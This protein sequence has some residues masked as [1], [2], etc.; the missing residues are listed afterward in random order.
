MLTSLTRR[1]VQR[2][3]LC[4]RLGQ[5]L[6]PAAATASAFDQP[7]TLRP[8][9]VRDFVLP[10]PATTEALDLRRRSFSTALNIH[11]NSEH[12]NDET[13]FEFTDESF[14]KIQQLLKKYPSN[15]KQS[16][17]IACLDIAQIQNGGWIPLS[18]MNKI[19][20]ILEMP[21]IKVYEVATFYTMFNREPIGKMHVMVCMTSPCMVRGSDELL[22]TLEKH[23][24]I[25]LGE[26]T[27]D[28][29]FTLGEMECMGACVNAPMIVVA[30]YRDPQHFTYHYYEDL[31]TADA[32]AVVE[33]YRKGGK[34]A[35]GPRN[36]RKNSA[37]LGAKTCLAAPP[38]G[39][40]CRDLAAAKQQWQAAQ[41]AAAA[42]A[43]AKK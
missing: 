26:T 41:A 6:R 5:P 36:G 1:I 24:G 11:V 25:H 13:P 28:G 43:A 17:V 2:A 15:Y 34:P 27:S 30:D 9:S 21:P 23:L 40:R 3:S 19:A 22:A 42:A 12:N 16:A 10:K 38:A 37:P 29:L 33:E 35:P 8:H 31:T 20:T 14:A 7:I 32:V 4:S 18:A 39:P